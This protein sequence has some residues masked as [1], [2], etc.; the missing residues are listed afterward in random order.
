MSFEPIHDIAP[1]LDHQGFNRAPLYPVGD[2]MGRVVEGGESSPY[3]EN[4]Q[5]M[6]LLRAAMSKNGDNLKS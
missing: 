4:T 6:T 5:Q 2:L 1:G 3:G